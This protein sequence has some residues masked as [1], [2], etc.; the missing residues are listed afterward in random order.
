[1][2]AV[3]CTAVLVACDVGPWTHANLEARSAD[4]P[5][6]PRW[7]DEAAL[8]R[9]IELAADHM[10]A[11]QKPSGL[12][13]Y[14]N[15]VVKNREN[16]D[17]N[18]IR[19][20]GAFWATALLLTHPEAHLDEARR[21]RVEQTFT[22]MSDWITAHTHPLPGTPGASYV[23]LGGEVQTGAN[24]LVALGYLERVKAGDTQ[25]VAPMRALLANLAA[26]RGEDG[27]FRDSYQ[28]RR[29][30][31]GKRS[32]PYADGEALLALAKNRAVLGDH[33]YDA[34]LAEAGPKLRDRWYG[35]RTG[36]DRKSFYQW[37]SMSFY[38]L[39]RSEPDHA[40]AWQDVILKYADWQVL[41]HKTLSRTRNT[42]YAVEGLATA[43][44]VAHARGDRTRMKSLRYTI[45]K[46]HARVISAQIGH[47]L[48]R[49]NAFV[50]RI[51]RARRESPR[52]LGGFLNGHADPNMRIDVTQHAIHSI[53]LTLEHGVLGVP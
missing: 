22:R 13:R 49:H 18:M 10:C 42:S 31:F 40:R 41:E 51:P 14:E 26:S 4:Y 1:L 34:L 48:D 24:A 47:P 23:D 33:T 43:Y 9:S 17:D 50:Q 11:Q 30:R 25:Y 5:G 46:T 52:L 6:D 15:D 21:Q 20:V 45:L 36:D 19:Q 3:W 12:F 37:G 28:V 27:S 8:R 32:N 7:I 38:W 39:A 2:L 53:L 44:A 16:P 29:R 35:S